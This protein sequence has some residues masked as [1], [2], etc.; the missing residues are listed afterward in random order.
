[1]P[2]EAITRLDATARR[3]GTPCGDGEMVW[4]C[5]GE[6]P[7]L[8]LFHGN[9]GTWLHWTHNIEALAQHYTVMAA[10]APGFG[11]SARPP[12]PTTA[13]DYGRVVADGLA[14]IVPEGEQA[15][16]VGFSYGGRLA[17]EAGAQRP[18]KVA[19]VTLVAPGGLGV[20]DAPR[21]ELAKLRPGMSPEEV[22]EVHR[23]NL[24][25]L[26]IAD[27]DA[28]DEL[29]VHI[30]RTNTRQVRFRMTAWPEEDIWD[31][32][33]RALPE[34]QAPMKGIWSTRDAFAGDSVPERLDLV[35]RHHPDADLRLLDGAG[36]WMQY[37]A[38]NAFNALL[39]EMLAA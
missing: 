1:M 22:Y 30:Q 37:E 24:A 28:V 14:Q 11:A 39:L 13:R 26:M 7:P 9:F 35:R 8:V 2:L 36:H 34:I 16:L 18:D 32:L 20:E 27:P 6:G 31:G 29:A 25:G 17:G 10:D 5:W 12:L 38:P 21:P 33:G 19:T 23:A 3:I 4:H 15:H